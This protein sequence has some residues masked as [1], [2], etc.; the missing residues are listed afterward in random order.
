MEYDPFMRQL[1]RENLVKQVN[2]MN[3]LNR[4]SKSII[5]F[6]DYL[7]HKKAK[8]LKRAKAFNKSIKNL[9]NISTIYSGK[10]DQSLFDVL[11]EYGLAKR[12]NDRLYSV[13]TKTA[14]ELMTFIAAVVGLKLNFLPTTDRMKWTFGAVGLKTKHYT[15]YKKI[16]SK[17]E[18]I[19][20]ELIPFPEEIEIRKIRKFKESH[21]TLLKSFKNQVELIA[22]DSTLVQDSDLFNEKIKELQIRKEEVARK[23]KEDRLGDIIFGTICGLATAGIGMAEARTPEGALLALPQFVNT[24]YSSLKIERPEDTFD[25]SGLKYLA[26]VDRR[27][28]K[29]ND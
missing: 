10:F 23:M 14:N 11:K 1:V 7:G 27:L 22:L 13:E 12:L 5:P 19:I 20:K 17:R 4:P 28:R 24:V 3:V 29:S 2:P 16:K 25:Q 21:P 26:L 18:K 15:E 8:T 9:T 6:I